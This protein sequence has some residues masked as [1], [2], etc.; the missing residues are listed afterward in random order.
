[1]NSNTTPTPR[2]NRARHTAFSGQKTDY[3]AYLYMAYVAE[4]IEIELAEKTN[5]V[6]RLREKLADIANMP[7]IDQDDEHRLRHKAQMALAP[8]PEEPKIRPFWECGCGYRHE[9]WVK[10]CPKCKQ[11]TT[12][13]ATPTCSNTTHKF[14][15]CDCEKPSEKDT[16]TETCAKWRELGPDEVIQ[17]G[18][19]YECDSRWKPV[20]HWAIGKNPSYFTRRFRTRRPLLVAEITMNQTTDTPRTDA[21]EPQLHSN[22]GGW[23][24]AD[25]AREL[26][27]ELTLQK[28]IT[29]GWLISR[30]VIIQERDG[31]QDEVER[32]R[33]QRNQ[34][35]E[36]AEK[37]WTDCS[38]G[39]EHTELVAL[40]GE[41]K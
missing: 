34:A 11:T 26:E 25:F 5:E 32:L 39:H 3:E 19:E 15:H 8:A 36:I 37:I 10:T 21:A 7:K 20:S 16:S 30:E 38:N 31:L 12:E 2:T 18:D 9:V 35:V 23:V 13:P 29:N 27:R 17:E 14:S 4:T 22:V 24:R 28:E 40:K 6:V 33:S 41:I 1:M